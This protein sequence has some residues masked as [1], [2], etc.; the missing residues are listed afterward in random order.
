ML[1]AFA[2]V[3]ANTFDVTH[4]NIDGEKRGF[5]PAQTLLKNSMPYHLESAPKR[6]NNVII[7][8][9]GITAQ[10]IQL[11]DLD[12]EAVQQMR[13]AAFLMLQTSPGNHQAWVAAPPADLARRLRERK[14]RRQDVFLRD[15]VRH[16]HLGKSHGA[17]VERPTNNREEG[18]TL[19]FSKADSRKIL[20]HP[21]ETTIEGLRDRAIL[22]VGCKWGCAARKSPRRRSA[23]CITNRGFDSLRIVRR[24]GTRDGSD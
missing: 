9:H 11:D 10:L 14:L 1:N 22:S 23:I 20:D 24:G 17:E 5:R 15:L 2:A 7:R 16:G 6:Q 12:A 19:A 8:P 18:T 21:D 4:I 3:G 13:P